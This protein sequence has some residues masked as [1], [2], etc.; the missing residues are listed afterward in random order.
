MAYELNENQQIELQKED[1]RVGEIKQQP[2]QACPL[3][4]LNDSC[5]LI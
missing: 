1:G 3:E 4:H 2:P 5:F